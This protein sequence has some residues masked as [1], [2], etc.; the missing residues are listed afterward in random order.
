MSRTTDKD[1][2][3]G[4]QVDEAIA[5]K[6]DLFVSIHA[7]AGGGDGFEGFYWSTSSNGKR[8]VQLAE[9][10]VKELGQNSRGAKKGDH[11][12]VIKNTPMTAVLFESFFLDNDKD[13]DIG[14]TKAEQKAFGVA[15][16]KAILEYFDIKYQKDKTTTTTAKSEYTQTQFV[17]DLQRAIGAQVDGIAGP[18][19]LSKTPTL[20][21]SKNTS[22]AAVKPVQKI[23][24]AMG[25]TEVGTAD[26]VAG[27]KFTSAVA[28][29]QQ[30]N[31]CYVD[32]EITARNLTWKKLLKLA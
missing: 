22:H 20:S 24:A 2:D 4:E 26:G 17:K 11:L 30:K 27:P 15:Y 31:G 9:K 23:L 12:Y 1:R 18:E 14:D 8:L 32:G 29:F 6:A 25:Y 5:S 10:Y 28:H 3:L 13:N 19:T 7:N 21:S 16:A